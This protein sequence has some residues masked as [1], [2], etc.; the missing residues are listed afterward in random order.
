MRIDWEVTGS[1]ATNVIFNVVDRYGASDQVRWDAAS[2]TSAYSGTATLAVDETRLA[3][4]DLVLRTFGAGNGYASSSYGVDGHADTWPYGI[5]S[6]VAAEFDYQQITSALESERDISVPPSLVSIH[7]SSPDVV[8]HGD[9]VRIDWEVTGSPATNVIFNVVDRYGASDQVRWDAASG[10]SAYSG[11]AT[12]AVDETRLAAGDL[13]LRTFGAGNGYASSSYGVDGHADTWP[14][15]ISSPV[16]AEFDYQQITSALESER[17]ISVPPSLVSIHRSSPDVVRH[18]DQV[19]IDWEVTGSPATNVIFNVVDRY[20]A[21]DQVR[22]DA[23]SGTSAYSGTATLAVD[24]TRLA[25]GDL[26][27]RTFGAGNGYASS[28]YGVDGHADTWPY[29]ISSP[30]AAEFDYQQI[31]SHLSPLVPFQVTPASAEFVDEDGTAEDTYTVPSTDGVEYLVGDK[32]VEAGTYPGSGTVTV[33][34]RA[35]TDYVLKVGAVTEWSATFKA[36]PFEVT[37]A[38]VVFTDKDGTAEDTYTVPVSEGVEYLVGDKVVEAGAHPGSGTVTVTARAKTDYVLKAGAVT[39]WSATFK[40]T[41][42]EVV[43]AAVVFTDKDGTAADTYVVPAVDGVEYLVGGKVVEAGTYPG[44]GTVTVTARAKTDYVLKA[45][46][47]TE[48]SATFKATPFEVVPAAVVFTDKDGTAADTYAVPAVDGVEYLVGGKVV[49]AGTYPGS[50]T[51]TVTAR[52]KTDYVLKAGAVTEWT[53]TFKV[54][55][56]E[57]VPA[58]V[59]FTDKDGTAAD[60]YAVPAVDGVEYL[61]GGKVVEAGTYPG[62]GTVTVTARAKTDYVLKAGAVTEWTVTFKVTPFEVVPA[63]VVFTDKDGTAADTYA[64][65]AVDGVEYLV[66]GKVVEAGTYPGVGTVTVTARAKADYVLKA[67]AVTEWTVTFKVTPFEVVPAAVVFTDKDGTAADTYAVPAVDGVEYLVGGKVVEAG[68][69]PG[70]GTVTVTA[71][72]KADYVL[73]AGAVTEWSATFKATPFEVVPAGVVFTDKDG[74]AE[75]TYTVPVSEGVEYLVGDKV[76]EA[77]AHPGS[78]TVTVVAR[79]KTDYVLKAGAVTEWTA[80]FKAT[81]FEVTPAAVIFTDKDGAAEDTYTVPETEGVEYLLGD[82]VVEAGTRPGTGSVTVTARAKADYVLKAG[83]VTEWTATFKAGPFEVTPAAVI[84]TDKDG[85]PQDTY[86]IPASEGVEYLVGGK[87]VAAGTYAGAGT[88]SITAKARAD[89]VLK[90]GAVASWSATFKAVFRMSLVVPAGDLNSDGKADLLARDSGGTLWL[91]PGNGRG[92]WLARTKVGGGW[93]VMNSLVGAG[94]LNGDRRADVLARDSAGTLWVYPGNGRGGWLAR[95]RVGAGWNVMNSIIGPGDVNGDGKS[96]VLA[97]DTAGTLWAYPG[98][99]RGGWLARIRVGGGWNAMTA[100][101]GPGDLTG[102][103]K[104]DI[105]ARDASGILWVYRGN[106]RGG[107]AS[108]TSTGAGWNA[109]GSIAGRGDF[110]GDGRTDALAI[111][112]A[113][114]LWLYRGNGAGN[115]LGRTSMGAGWN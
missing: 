5:S 24:E 50:G 11:T 73:K 52:A 76:V 28:S 104:A 45:G 13:V 75:D 30:V 4:G 110:N 66:G 19:R 22:W 107:F 51:V 25:A 108:R 106:G 84:F 23:A 103:R 91:Y 86:T 95:I 43:P 48:W 59:V 40:A 101:V 1:P 89:Y 114:V 56:F 17:D 70:V 33:T 80:T 46:A 16:A 55:P 58:A 62:S 15:G 113:G 61:V 10:T 49:E 44:S 41:P 18:G 98:N 9:Q 71:R 57:V 60:T 35:K 7:R 20:G 82:K 37:P 42:F 102:D 2:G 64:V 88:V 99:G 6:P 92:G 38:A 36:T 87:A 74:T 53:V 79:A 85:T 81:P 105:L 77:G 47:V 65:P 109:M 12:L 14:Y 27:L 78:G 67:G 97:R 34:V 100:V 93:N 32:V 29:G 54:T 26:V 8:R 96:D 63:A 72:A 111:D 90:A 39:E 68:T 83:A 94:D 31:T 112:A 69:Y 115:W 3:A 21:S